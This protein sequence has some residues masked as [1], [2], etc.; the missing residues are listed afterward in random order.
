MNIIE[1]KNLEKVYLIKK[2]EEGVKGSI[3]GLF[4]PEKE[5]KRAVSGVSFEIE[6]GKI[7]GLVG[8]NGAG[9]TTILKMLS[10]LIYPTGGE[11]NV[12][13]IKPWKRTKSFQKNLAFILGQKQQLWW[14]LPAI[15]SFYL[16]KEIY[17]IGD[18]EFKETLDELVSLL[19][20][21]HVLSTPVRN[22][23]LGERMKMEIIAGLL[24]KPKLVFLDE[25][26]IG[27]DSISQKNIIQFLKEYNKKYGSTIIL[28]SHYMKDIEMLCEDLILINKGT[29]IY[30]GPL[31]EMKKYMSQKKM[32]TVTCDK[33][34][35]N[36]YLDKYNGKL[37]KDGVSATFTLE[38]SN[39]IDC[40]NDLMTAYQIEDINI[41]DEALEDIIEKMLKR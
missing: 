35:E 33:E 40:I 20:V 41:A 25:P 29:I 5:E 18:S 31:N 4:S 27:L 6:E 15:E 32:L 39:L 30:K 13:G 22:L 23:S 19:N 36:Q 1:A 8:P 11:L 34:C 38:K 14:D 16:N 28:T 10:G 17:G 26:T 2:K 21:E 9:K 3:K 24:H 12:M 7:I 37:G